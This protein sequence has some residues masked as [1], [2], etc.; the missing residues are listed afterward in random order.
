M[1][2]SLKYGTKSQLKKKKKLKIVLHYIFLEK[3]ILVPSFKIIDLFEVYPISFNPSFR[4]YLFQRLL[5]PSLFVYTKLFPTTSD[6]INKELNIGRRNKKT[7]M[8]RKFLT[9]SIFISFNN[10]F[11]TI[12]VFY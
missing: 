10:P 7:S 2:V 12:I 1:N 3:S 9:N 4:F 5:V 6:N 8:P 11:K